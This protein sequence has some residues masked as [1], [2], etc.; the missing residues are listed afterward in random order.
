[1]VYLLVKYCTIKTMLAMI[2]NLLIFQ[3]H[4]YNRRLR[5]A[6]DD[7]SMLHIFRILYN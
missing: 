7:S 2:S 1:M 6:I 3:S 4:E 5:T